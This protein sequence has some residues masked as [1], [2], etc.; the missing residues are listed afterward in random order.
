MATS[1]AA[2]SVTINAG[3]ATEAPVL[4]SELTF[5]VVAAGMLAE[6]N[7]VCSVWGSICPKSINIVAIIMANDFFCIIYSLFINCL[8]WLYR[9]IRSFVSG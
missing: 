9:L 4:L 7:A 5:T 2:P 3:K 1:A 6:A 8:H